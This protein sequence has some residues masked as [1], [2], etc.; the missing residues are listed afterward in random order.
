MTQEDLRR[1]RGATDAAIRAIDARNEEAGEAINWTNP[2]PA[3]HPALP[4]ILRPCYVFVEN[5]PGRE[6]CHTVN[7]HGESAD[8]RP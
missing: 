5:V 4:R 8:K 3:T 1:L 6:G 2:R 7:L